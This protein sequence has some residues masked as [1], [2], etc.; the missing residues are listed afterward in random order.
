MPECKHCP[1]MRRAAGGIELGGQV[2]ILPFCGTLEWPDVVNAVVT[3]GPAPGTY[4][5][6]FVTDVMSYWDGWWIND[7]IDVGSTEGTGIAV[8]W[9]PDAFDPIDALIWPIEPLFNPDASYIERSDLTC[10][11]F[12]MTYDLTGPSA[13]ITVVIEMPD[14]V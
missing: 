4:P 9:V 13:G 7:S 3:G 2:S 12:R 11:P 8:V 14:E 6:T 1:R 10:H 5:L